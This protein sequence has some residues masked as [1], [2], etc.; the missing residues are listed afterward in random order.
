MS[1]AP[2]RRARPPAPCSCRRP[3]SAATPGTRP[4]SRRSSSLRRTGRSGGPTSRGRRPS[5]PAR[6]APRRNSSRSSAH[7]LRG[8][9]VRADRAEVALDEL[10]VLVG[11]EVLLDRLAGTEDRQLDRLATEL[12]DR[13]LALLL[14][15]AAGPVQQVGLVLLGLLDHVGA[16]LVGR[17][18]GVGHEL[19]R[20]AARRVEILLLLGE[21]RGSRLAI[22]LR[23][24]NRL[25]EGF[26]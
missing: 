16:N 22:A 4:A 21:Q 20:L 5:A 8:H 11:I 18:A 24:F 15:V 25:F 1:P 19:L 26:L 9:L 23:A 6:S 2:A 12:R 10:A 7:A 3:R 14:D 13:L 17:R